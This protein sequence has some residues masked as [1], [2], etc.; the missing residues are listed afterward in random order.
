MSTTGEGESASGTAE[1]GA[2]PDVAVET[3][4]SSTVLEQLETRI[5]EKLLA[6]LAKPGGPGPGGEAGT[7]ASTGEGERG[8]LSTVSAV[9]FFCGLSLILLP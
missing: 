8:V 4:L 7:S 1:A 2:G 6:R 5:V 9:Q 3:P